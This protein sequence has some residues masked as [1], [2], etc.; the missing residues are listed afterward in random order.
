MQRFFRH[1]SIYIMTPTTDYRTPFTK[2][3]DDCQNDLHA[4]SERPFSH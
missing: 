4:K 1:V 3:R 2:K